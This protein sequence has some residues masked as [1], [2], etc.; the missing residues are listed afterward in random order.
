[1]M[2]VEREETSPMTQARSGRRTR[3]GGEVGGNDMREEEEGARS[4]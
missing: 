4:W 1:M 2:K 3:E